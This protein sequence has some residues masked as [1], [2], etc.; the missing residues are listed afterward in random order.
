M[1]EL[2]AVRGAGAKVHG[3]LLKWAGGDVEN[4]RTGRLARAVSRAERRGGPGCAGAGGDAAGAEPF[5]RP[6]GPG[7]RY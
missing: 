3:A 7:P 4:D 5:P 2:R 1:G 6:T